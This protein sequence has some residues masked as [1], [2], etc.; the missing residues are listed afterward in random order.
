[1]SPSFLVSSRVFC[2]WRLP[3]PSPALNQPVPVTVI[4]LT[5]HFCVLPCRKA[6]SSP[7]Q[8]KALDH[9][10][11]IGFPTTWCPFAND[12]VPW[13]LPLRVRKNTRSLVRVAVSS[14]HKVKNLDPPSCP[15]I[16]L[17]P[18]Q[19][20]MTLHLN[21]VYG[22][23][24]KKG[25]FYK[26]VHHA[27]QF[28]VVIPD[29]DVDSKEFITTPDEWASFEQ[30]DADAVGDPSPSSSLAAEEEVERYLLHGDPRMLRLSDLP[31][32]L[33]G[34]GK[35]YFNERSAAARK[36][37]DLVLIA[38][39]L[40]ASQRGDYDV[41]PDYHPLAQKPPHQVMNFYDARTHPG[42][43][44]RAFSNLQHMDTHLGRSLREFN[45]LIGIPEST[46]AAI[47]THNAPCRNCQWSLLYTPK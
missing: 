19:C 43:L 34:P 27:C 41:E 35:P 4:R 17:G 3:Y 25:N 33:C 11:D 6:P 20:R 1:M 18:T 15:H 8:K 31:D 16:D 22:A 9:F 10:N 42:S 7:R 44:V 14:F 45:S 30:E 24:G 12:W 40:A 39:V 23:H 36:S 37:I 28:L 2:T 5:L 26:A 47:L 13:M 38:D 29:V 46:W 32:E 21:H